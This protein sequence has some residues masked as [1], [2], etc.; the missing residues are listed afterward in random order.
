MEVKLSKSKRTSEPSSSPISQALSGPVSGGA[1]EYTAASLLS[2]CHSNATL[3][4]ILKLEEVYNLAQLTD[5]RTAYGIGDYI[6][7]LKN[8]IQMEQLTHITLLSP[9]TAKHLQDLAQSKISDMNFTKFTAVLEKE[10]TKIDLT[11]FIRR[12][13]EL[14]DTVY[15]FDSTRSIAPKL[16]NE[17]LWL[18]TMNSLVAE[19]RETVGRL[20]V[21]A[22]QFEQN[23]I[24]F[25][26]II[27]I[28]IIV[29]V[30]IIVIVIIMSSFQ[31]D[32]WGA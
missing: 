11:S 8:K 4:N 19:M 27:I 24:K 21:T 23:I 32:G 7:N 15:Q 14:K 26:V 25:I 16:E 3:F 31:G 28:I 10:I 2:S 20:K 22:G 30:I 12:L 9:E 13:K 6:E 5:W 18:G 1:T 17:A 29:V